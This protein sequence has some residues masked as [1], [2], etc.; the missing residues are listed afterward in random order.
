MT[1]ECLSLSVLPCGPHRSLC[2]PT[3]PEH[4]PRP[5]PTSLHAFHMPC[6]ISCHLKHLKHQSPPRK[7]RP[8]RCPSRTRCSLHMAQLAVC[9][10]GFIRSRDW[11]GLSVG[12][13][14]VVWLGKNLLNKVS[15]QRP[16]NTCLL[17]V[18]ITTGVHRG[19]P[20]HY[21]SW[22]PKIETGSHSCGLRTALRCSAREE[23]RDNGMPR[24]NTPS[25]YKRT[26]KTKS[27]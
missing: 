6:R 14:C 22:T 2:H 20:K 13:I 23:Q 16:T 7:Q 27:L 5:V 4:L 24:K 18:T 1:Q 12:H 19:N 10:H 25:K 3:T 17:R 15:I 11:S 9:I 26:R 8:Q 21:S